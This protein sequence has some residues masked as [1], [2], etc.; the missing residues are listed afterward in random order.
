MYICINNSFYKKSYL[1]N[2][3][4][5]SRPPTRNKRF[6]LILDPAS[7]SFA[8]RPLRFRAKCD[9]KKSQ[10]L[11]GKQASGKA[12]EFSSRFRLFGGFSCAQ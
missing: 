10:N 9:R 2:M 4:F 1:G 7:I 11:V 8:N 6:P 3:F 5:R 12:A